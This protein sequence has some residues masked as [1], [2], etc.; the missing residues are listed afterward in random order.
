M[1]IFVFG[2]GA[3]GSLLARLLERRGHTV[4][5]GDKNP[6]RARR[7]LGPSVRVEYVNAR[8]LWSI[9]RAGRSCHLV[10]NAVPAAF[11]HTVLRAAL[12][13]RAHYLDLATHLGRYAFKAE[14]LRFHRKFLAKRRT[15][16]INAGVAPGLT[17]L[18][19]ARAGELLDEVE[20]VRVRLYESTESRDPVSTWSAETA[21]DE[22]I[23]RPCVYR[24]GRFRFGQRFGEAEWFRFPAPLG[25]VRAV[26][27]AQDEVATV[28]HFIRMRAM[29]VKIGGNE[30]ARLRRWYRQGKLR[31]SRR[32]VAA[33][34]PETLTPRAIARL[35][36]RGRLRNA[37]FGAAVVASGQ[38]GGQPL[39]LEWFSTVPTLYQLRRTGLN[40]TPIAFATA[41]MAALFIKHFPRA[42]G[43]VHP[44]EALPG[45]VRRAI[46]ADV[47]SRGFLL[48]Q[49]LR[50]LPKPEDEEE[51]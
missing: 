49:R 35:I 30:M 3:T 15:A 37:R 29:D 42:L 47:K 36:R 11:N 26:L 4:W 10:V 8:N 32:P 39:R 40:T 44:P 45:E 21:F 6:E 2:A 50:R 48:S 5:C 51:F 25:R 12:R 38:K 13:L 24:E 7:F 41:H 27:A 14:Q 28:P 17:N 22:A 43:G 20:E 19:A 23:S 31:G 34:F 16:I 46:L 1:R 9:V 18:L 33:R